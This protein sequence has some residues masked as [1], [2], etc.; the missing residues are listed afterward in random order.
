[1]SLKSRSSVKITA[2]DKRPWNRLGMDR[3]SRLPP[4]GVRMA[5]PRNSSA[6]MAASMAMG[7]TPR[8][9]GAGGAGTAGGLGV[10][11]QGSMDSQLDPAGEDEAERLRKKRQA[12]FKSKYEV[13]ERIVSRNKALVNLVKVARP[14]CLSLS[15]CLSL[16]FSLSRALSPFS[17][18]LSLSLSLSPSLSLSGPRVALGGRPPCALR[19][20]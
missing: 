20:G 17:L 3:L 1:M 7:G 5:S 15:I 2:G 4:T 13:D 9:R 10:F 14:L 12:I 19:G 8:G 11:S 16:S 18:S 6:M